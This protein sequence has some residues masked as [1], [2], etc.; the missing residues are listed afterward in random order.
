MS[1]SFFLMIKYDGGNGIKRMRT[2]VAEEVSKLEV[3]VVINHYSEAQ[4]QAQL[5]PQLERFGNH[6]ISKLKTS[7][8]LFKLEELVW[9]SEK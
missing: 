7:M 3:E 2:I 8:Q 6:K 5:C 4:L 1:L 9:K